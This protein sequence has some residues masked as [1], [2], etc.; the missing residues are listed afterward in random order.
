MLHLI[1]HVGEFAPLRLTWSVFLS[2][3]VRVEVVRVS[4][5]PPYPARNSR[6]LNTQWAIIQRSYQ[7]NNTKYDVAF[8]N[9]II[10]KSCKGT[11]TIIS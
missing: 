2:Q 10:M 8:K 7:Q 11:G 9:L 4:G 5:T 6:V 1:C 3:G